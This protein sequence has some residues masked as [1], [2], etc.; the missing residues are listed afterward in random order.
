MYQLHHG[1]LLIE[2]ALS[3][4]SN[5]PV[6]PQRDKHVDTAGWQDGC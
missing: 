1:S 2:F 3:M 6:M 4:F 5:V